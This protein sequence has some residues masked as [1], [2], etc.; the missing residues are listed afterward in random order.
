[1]R[2]GHPDCIVYD[3]HVEN[4]VN[5]T[6]EEVDLLAVVNRAENE[7]TGR[8]LSN[9]WVGEVEWTH[10]TRYAWNILLER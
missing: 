6:T 2:P 10:A 1:V 8:T 3:N 4:M 7:V 9:Y 5:P